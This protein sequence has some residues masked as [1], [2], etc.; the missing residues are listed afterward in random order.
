M[1]RRSFRSWALPVVLA[2]AVLPLAACG[3]SS[4]PSESP[5]AALASAKKTLD[6]TSGVQLQL[7]GSDLPDGNALV[8]ADGT[9]T[10][11]PAFDGSI[12]VQLLGTTANVPVIAVDSKVYAK[13]PLTTSWQTIDPSQYG[14]P[15]PASLISPD[16]GISTLLT[17]TEDPKTGD[18]VRGGEGNKLVLTTYTGTLPASA[19]ARIIPT[20]SGTFA[21]SYTIDSHHELSQA[22]LKGRFYGADQPA[23]TYTV[24][25][26]GYG[27]DK[28]ITR[29]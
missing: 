21:A 12:S 14:V 8:G 15:D 20:A 4:S 26:D 2:A 17:A 10:H 9:L 22:V 19:V 11:A 25:L 7:K 3:G 1:L 16:T 18:S 23:S 5:S 27:T 13:L 28:T 29:P 24:T 6:T